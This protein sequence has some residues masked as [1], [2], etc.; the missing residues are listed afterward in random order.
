MIAGSGGAGISESYDGDGY[1]QW[2]ANGGS[3][4][5]KT[6]TMTLQGGRVYRGV[7]GSKPVNL[8]YEGFYNRSAP[9]GGASSFN[10]Q[11]ARGGG[12]A[13][14]HTEHRHDGGPTRYT[15]NGTS[16][17]SG[18]AGGSFAWH[19]KGE[20]DSEKQPQGGYVNISCDIKGDNN[21]STD[22][23]WPSG[24]TGDI[25]LNSST[26]LFRTGLVGACVKLYHNMPLSNC[27]A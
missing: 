23:L 2:V 7:V 14:F 8:W 15:T 16:Y 12:G 5:V 21:Y 26:R 1:G 25:T 27:Y 19:G 9:D 11:S 22:G 24:V 4:E 18:P 6:L 13:S 3:A 10:G 20:I 17:G